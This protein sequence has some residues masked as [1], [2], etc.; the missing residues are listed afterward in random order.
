[1]WKNLSKGL[2]VHLWHSSCHELAPPTLIKSFIHIFIHIHIGTSL[3]YNRSFHRADLCLYLQHYFPGE[4]THV[5]NTPVNWDETPL[6]SVLHSWQFNRKILGSHF[7]TV[8]PL[9]SNGCLG[10]HPKT[11]K[12]DKVSPF[13]LSG[14]PHDTATM[15]QRGRNDKC[16]MFLRL[17]HLGGMCT[18]R[19]HCVDS[20]TCADCDLCFPL[21]T[22]ANDLALLI[23]RM[24]SS[25][26]QVEKNILQAEELLALVGTLDRRV[27]L[28]WSP[29]LRFPSYWSQS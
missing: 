26:D 27:P 29:A 24:Q 17:L 13:H 7:A 2:C 20:L 4:N 21:R 5:F 10:S 11:T 9:F 28:P 3:K 16:S 12:A 1:M 15:S 23:A 18:G 19:K 6:L 14:A 25:A 8:Q 22:Q